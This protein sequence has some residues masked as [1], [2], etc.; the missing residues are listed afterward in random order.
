MKTNDSNV[1]V[2]IK[3]SDSEAFQEFN[4]LVKNMI[5]DNRIDENIRKEYHKKFNEVLKKFMD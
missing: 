4:V 1:R 2:V 3:I 5:C